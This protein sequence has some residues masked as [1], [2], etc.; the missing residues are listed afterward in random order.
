MNYTRFRDIPLL[1]FRLVTLTFFGLLFEVQVLQF[2]WKAHVRLYE[3]L[4]LI[5]TLY[6]TRH[7]AFW[8]FSL[9]ISSATMHLGI[10]LGL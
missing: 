4:L 1:S 10:F 5:R 9:S 8:S 7:L 3:G 6:L 2:L